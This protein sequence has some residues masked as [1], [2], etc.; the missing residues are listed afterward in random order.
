MQAYQD[1]QR[2]TYDLNETLMIKNMFFIRGVRLQAHGALALPRRWHFLRCSPVK[3]R[4]REEAKR[5][6][7]RYA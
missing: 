6:V 4:I 5:P 2:T 1:V 7:Q 3:R